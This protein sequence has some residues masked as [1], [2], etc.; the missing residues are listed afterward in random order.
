[1]VAVL[2]QS[3]IPTL[4]QDLVCLNLEHMFPSDMQLQLPDW[5]FDNLAPAGFGGGDGSDKKPSAVREEQLV[6]NVFLNIP[7]MLAIQ[8]IVGVLERPVSGSQMVSDPA[9]IKA[10]ARQAGIET[11]LAA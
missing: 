8:A 10:A 9:I 3:D 5:N 6:N 2:Q 4:P 11:I 7:F 1:M